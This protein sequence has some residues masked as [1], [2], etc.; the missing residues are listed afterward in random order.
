MARPSRGGN[1]CRPPGWS[2]A[3]SSDTSGTRLNASRDHGARHTGPGKLVV[4]G[5]RVRIRPSVEADAEKTWSYRR[6]PSVSRWLPREAPDL[7][8][9]R[10]AFVEPWRLER[11][12]VFEHDDQVI[13]DLYLHV[14]D[15]WAQ[16]EV[17]DRG[18][19]VE[20]ELGWV[21][22]PAFGGRGL[23]TDAVE[24]LLD[25]CFDQLHLHRVTASCHALN[26]PSWRLMERIGMRRE[27]HVVRASMHRHLGW[28]DGY[29]YSLLNSERP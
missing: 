14:R 27:S 26:Q 10:Q 24:L 22:N 29:S 25:A 7:A 2:P 20:A 1:P 28:I 19:H 13:G 15:A 12:L 11:T 17:A 16:A 23:A 9:Y 4:Q 5:E 8:E 3:V 21:L 6:L 18:R